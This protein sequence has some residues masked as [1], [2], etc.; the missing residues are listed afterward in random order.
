MTENMN[1]YYYQ[2][3]GVHKI[4][5]LEIED[6]AGIANTL[7]HYLRAKIKESYEAYNNGSL[8]GI[9]L[10][11]DNVAFIKTEVQRHFEPLPAL[12][13]LKK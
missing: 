2:D 1:N 7:S 13:S 4:R 9:S 11:P 8:A 6:F 10:T 3:P 5:N 12:N